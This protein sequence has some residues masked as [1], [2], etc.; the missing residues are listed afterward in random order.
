MPLSTPQPRSLQHTRQVRCEGFQRTDGLWDIEGHLT[1]T[2]SFA[3]ECKERNDGIIPVG[4]PLHGMSI[5]ITVDLDLNILDVEAAMDYTPFRICPQIT[6]TYKQLIGLQIA[7][8]FT[9]KVRQLFGGING[10]THLLELLGPVATTAYQATHQAREQQENWADGDQRPPML[11][12]CHTMAS[13]GP[14]VRE[15]WPHFYEG[16]NA[17]LIPLVRATPEN[18]RAAC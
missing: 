13:D 8:G 12:S 6:E 3:M 10:C 7:P 2:K 16:D 14:V 18:E 5:R 1:D 17:E 9:K 11:D 15:H 4:E